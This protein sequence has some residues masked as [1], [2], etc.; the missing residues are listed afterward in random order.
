[1]SLHFG[2]EL[3]CQFED[4]FNAGLHRHDDVECMLVDI[5]RASFN[6]DRFCRLVGGPTDRLVLTDNID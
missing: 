4:G 5:N 1:M 3:L 6:F 2:E